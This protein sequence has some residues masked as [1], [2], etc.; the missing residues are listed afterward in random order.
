LGDGKEHRIGDVVEP[1]AKQLGLSEEETNE[2]LPSG[3]QTIFANRVH[4]AKTYLAQAKLLEIT[5]RAYFRLTERGRD[6]LRENPAKVDVQ[7]L[8]RFPEFNE[9]K[10]RSRNSQGATSGP[11]PTVPEPTA[12]LATP[13]ELLR[14]TIA[15]LDAA[16]SSE[17]LDRI[18]A[19]PP[20]FF[21]SLIV[22]LL[23]SMG[24]G[25]SREEAGRAIGKSGDGG[26][27][28]VIDQDP[29]GLDRIYLQAKRYSADISVSE[30]EIRGF[31]GSL[32]AAKANKGVFV[33]TSYF[34]KPAM[35]FA[36]RH[37]FKLVLIDGKQLTALMLRHN[38]GVRVSE[39][40]HVKK[41]DEDFF[42]EE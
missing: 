21:E 29:L 10:Q 8:E 16:L 9:F 5:R 38:V 37:P 22:T 31:S 13:D 2:V 17:L 18:L 11:Q 24:Y 42:G 41:L 19:A 12:K 32:G 35:D 4:W 39:T 14:T 27:D 15:D 7:L 34:T 26:I 25:G 6:V 23:L 33:T 3:K 1:L 40:L 28:G 30:P 36:E 20:A